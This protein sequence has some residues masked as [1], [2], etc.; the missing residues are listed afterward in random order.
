[1][2]KMIIKHLVGSKAN[3]TQ[4]FEL[5][6]TELIFGRDNTCQVVFDPDQDDLVSRA[7]CK[8]TLQ[9]GDQFFLE[10]LHST[11]GT[12]VN[13]LK[14]TAPQRLNAGDTVA[15]GKDG[16]QFVFDLDPRPT[17]IGDAIPQ[18]TRPY[19][20]ANPSPSTGMGRQTIERLIQQAVQNRTRLLNIGG[21]VAGVLLAVGTGFYLYAKPDNSTEIFKAYANTTVLIESSWQL[22]H[23]PTG[24]QLFQKTACY[25]VKKECEAM[26]WYVLVN[27]IVEP[28]LDFDGAPIGRAG[29]GSGFVVNEN[30]YILTNRHVAANWH[31]Q[32]GNFKFPGV[33]VNC[34]DVQCLDPTYE[35]IE[36]ENNEYLASLNKWVPA[37]TKMF[38]QKPLIGKVVEG[39]N[40][41]LDVKFPK[42]GLKIPARLVG[43]SDRADVA[44]IKVDVPQKLQTVTMSS[45]DPIS[46]GDNVTVMG[47]P[48]ISPDIAVKRRSKDQYDSEPEWQQIPDPTVTGGNV[49]KVIQAPADMNS[50]DTYSEMGDTYQLTVNATGGG[51]SGGP[52]FNDQG[53]VIGIFTYKMWDAKGTAITFAVP[54]KYG[55]EIMGISKAVQ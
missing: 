2:Q 21:M 22:I 44:L 23:A 8:I 17:R 32:R 27:G 47:Y 6:I 3:Q 11:N 31:A 55:Q 19:H 25:P 53:H 18:P 54:I 34:D 30:G 16:T 38:G 35:K 15:L 51:N 41:Y 13:A 20:I 43:V 9:Q 46:A 24:K 40:D 49:G 14:I 39:R 26:P 48:G 50:D 37:N 4:A 45:N 28:F 33:L 1:M 42:T 29:A 7:H 52:V 10:D 12:F 5:P 36:D